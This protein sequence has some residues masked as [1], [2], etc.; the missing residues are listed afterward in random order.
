MLCII[1]TNKYNTSTFLSGPMNLMV[2]FTL[3]QLR[4]LHPVLCSDSS[5][6]ASTSCV[7]VSTPVLTYT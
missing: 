1:Y 2:L 6:S 3:A 4:N 5:S 7:S